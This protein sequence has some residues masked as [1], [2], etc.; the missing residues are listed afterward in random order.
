MTN[1]LPLSMFLYLI[2]LFDLRQK[3]GKLVVEDLVNAGAK[4]DKRWWVGL[5]RR[6]CV[7]EGFVV[8]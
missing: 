5:F 6:M 3:L 4:L 1:H 8:G 2:S 7:L